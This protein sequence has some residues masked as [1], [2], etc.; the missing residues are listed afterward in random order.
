MLGCNISFGLN[1]MGGILI[2]IVFRNKS[3]K[4]IAKLVKKTIGMA[5]SVKPVLHTPLYWTKSREVTFVCNFFK[6]KCLFINKKKNLT[7]KNTE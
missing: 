2:K 7:K 6:G 1:T 3:L 4:Q 5:I